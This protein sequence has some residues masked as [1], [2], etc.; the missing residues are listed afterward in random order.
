MNFVSNS[1]ARINQRPPI[2]WAP[3]LGLNSPLAMYRM[4]ERTDSR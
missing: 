1:E 2:L 4:S 3:L